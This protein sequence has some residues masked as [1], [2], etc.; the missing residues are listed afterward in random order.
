MNLPGLDHGFQWAGLFQYDRDDVE[1]G[2]SGPHARGEVIDA[3]HRGEPLMLQRL[4]PHDGREGQGQRKDVDAVSGMNAKLAG[5]EN[6]QGIVLA[7]GVLQ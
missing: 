7:S 3:I 1:R 2:Q 6:A 4:H 5:A